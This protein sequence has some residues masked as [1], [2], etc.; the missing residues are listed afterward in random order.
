MTRSRWWWGVWL[1]LACACSGAHRPGGARLLQQG[2]TVPVL[3]DVDHRGG[4]LKVPSDRTMVVYFYPKDGTPGCTEE[5]CAFR[6]VWD[7][8]EAAHVG[9]IGISPDP[10]SRHREFADEHHLPF[11]LVSDADDAWARAYGV[12]EVLGML[13][14][15]TFVVDAMGRVVMVYPDVD[16]GVHAMEILEDLRGLGLVP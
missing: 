16:P 11:P 8:Y 7:R 4:A 2:E 1:L 6:D 14:R 12:G 5:A 15:V 9:V 10:P 3:V 13:R